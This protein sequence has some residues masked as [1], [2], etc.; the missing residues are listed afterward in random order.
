MNRA[1]EAL[2]SLGIEVPLGIGIISFD[3]P[4]C[5]AFMRSPIT[6]V[7][8]PTERMGLAALEMLLQ[9]AG[10]GDPSP[11]ELLFPAELVIR[12]SCGA[13]NADTGAKF[14]DAS[15]MDQPEFGPLL[16]D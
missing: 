15:N 7:R 8:Q 9:R 12:N 10:G 5:F 13:E 6:A 16:H 14:Y 3:D 11:K 1:L 2:Q 4:A